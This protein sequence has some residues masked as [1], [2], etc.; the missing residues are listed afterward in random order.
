[1]SDVTFTRRT[2]GQLPAAPRFL[3]SVRAISSCKG[4]FFFFSVL[5]FVD[6]RDA[7]GVDLRVYTCDL[8]VRDLVSATLVCT[9]MRCFKL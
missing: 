9:L 6:L 2:P 7:F 8:V 4:L 3:H 1:M 5:F